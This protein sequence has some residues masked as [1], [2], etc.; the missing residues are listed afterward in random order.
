MERLLRLFDPQHPQ[1][2]NEGVTLVKIKFLSILKVLC[3][4]L[5]QG[6]KVRGLVE[7]RVVGIGWK[8]SSQRNSPL[9]LPKEENGLFI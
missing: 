9:S 2:Q 3:W 7:L 4:V 5:V 6:E 8:E 1:W